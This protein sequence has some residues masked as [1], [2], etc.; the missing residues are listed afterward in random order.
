MIAA[1]GMLVLSGGGHYLT[2]V[3]P[4]MLVAGVG[5]GLVLVSVSVSILAGAADTRPGC[6][7]G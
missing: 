1:A 4:G 7:P 6:C 5:L 2:H 3:L